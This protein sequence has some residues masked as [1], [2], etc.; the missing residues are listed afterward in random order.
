MNI[1]FMGTPTYAAV[2]LESL[3]KNHNIKAL[4]CQSDKKSG[5]SMQLKMPPT[6]AL[7]LNKK[8]DIP[9][10]QDLNED[11][12]KSLQNIPCDM[13]IVAAF[14]RILSREVLDIAPCINLHASILPKFRGASPIQASILENEKYFGV[15]VM[16]M[17]EGLDCGDILGIKVIKNTQQNAVELFK[18][19]SHLAAELILEFLE[20][21]DCVMPLKQRECESSFCKKIKKEFG[22]VVL[23]NA[24]E[25]VVKSLAYESW[26]GI[27][28]KNGLKMRGLILEEMESKNPAGLILKV[29]KEKVL[30][31][32]KMGSMWIEFLQSPSKN[33]VSAYQYLQGKRLKEGDILE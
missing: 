26:P 15:S 30:V 18:Q 9:I 5:R 14:G 10:F 25:I 27:F 22:E 31:G 28:L 3:L 24:Q 8:L 1:I 32:A 4:V 20:R 2:I 17:E 21:I 29:T 11:T 19:L 7:I 13:I 23:D 12:I 33:I 6:K 16:K